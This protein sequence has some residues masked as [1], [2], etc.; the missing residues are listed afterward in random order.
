MSIKL[1]VQKEECG[2][3][4]LGISKAI[5]P[6]Q[7]CLFFLA[8]ISVIS[9]Y[10]NPLLFILFLMRF[11]LVRLVVVSSIAPIEKPF[12]VYFLSDFI[13]CLFG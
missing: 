1:E 6:F 12:L 4:I 8:V 3:S 11:S 5:I 13:V 10:V 2:N 9:P 7:R